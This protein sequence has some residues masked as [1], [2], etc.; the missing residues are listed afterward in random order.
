MLNEILRPTDTTPTPSPKVTRAMWIEARVN[1]LQAAGWKNPALATKRA[2]REWRNQSP[3]HKAAA[4]RNN[5]MAAA[6]RE[7]LN[8]LPASDPLA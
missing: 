3:Q 2:T 1:E 8:T 6:R 7:R 4:K 5:D